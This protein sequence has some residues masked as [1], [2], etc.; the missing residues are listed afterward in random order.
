VIS[1]VR[2]SAQQLS[3]RVDFGPDLAL[4]SLAVDLPTPFMWTKPTASAIAATVSN[5][6][7][8][9]SPASLVTFKI[10]GVGGTVYTMPDVPVLPL[11][12]NAAVAMTS[13]LLIP[14][15][16]LY[17]IT[18]TVQPGGPDLSSQ[19]NTAMLNFLAATRQVYLPLALRAGP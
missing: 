16:G 4:A 10:L 2:R 8:L 17:V 12:P 15:P 13:T 19:N 3:F 18:A 5:T 1:Q 11:A 7:Y 6:T 9:T 14:A